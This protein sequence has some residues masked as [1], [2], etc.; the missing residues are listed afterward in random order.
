MDNPYDGDSEQEDDEVCEKGDDPPDHLS[1]RGV[2]S[3][4]ANDNDTPD[5]PSTRGVDAAC[6]I[7]DTTNHLG[8]KGVRSG[9]VVRDRLNNPALWTWYDDDE[10]PE[11]VSG[12]CSAND[13]SDLTNT[14]SSDEPPALVTVSESSGDDECEGETTKLRIQRATVTNRQH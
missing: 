11:L 4:Y 8:L 13:T 12:S 6:G 10:P 7:N 14:S 1:T 2:N 9:Y 5:H 3:A